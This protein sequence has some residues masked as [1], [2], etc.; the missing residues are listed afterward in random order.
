M[1]SIIGQRVLVLVDEANFAGTARK[2]GRRPDWQQLRDYLANP[3][4]GRHLVEM[5]AYLGLPPDHPDYREQRERKKGFL[6][7]LQTNG[8]FAVVKEGTPTEDGRY[9]ANVDVLMAVDGVRLAVD[10]RPDTVVI[11]SGDNEFAYLAE[12]LRRRGIRVEVASVADTLSTQLKAAANGFID[13]TPVL[14][15]SPGLNGQAAQIGESL[16]DLG[17][18]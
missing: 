18:L 16:D 4:E 11:V 17:A 9:R 14:N 3:G 2:F 5:V 13:L 6:S 15:A 12:T 8:F 10:M 7:W 1:A